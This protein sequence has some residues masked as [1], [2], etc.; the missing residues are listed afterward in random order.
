MCHCVIKSIFQQFFYSLNSECWKLKKMNFT[1]IHAM[2]IEVFGKFHPQNGEQCPRNPKMHILAWVRIVWA[3]K[4]EN[5]STGLTCSSESSN[6]QNQTL[7]TQDWL[8]R[9][10]RDVT[11]EIHNVSRAGFKGRQ[12]GQ[13][14]RASTTNG[15]PQ[16]TVKKLLPKKT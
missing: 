12:T 6:W 13:L 15:P 3:I 9:A 11:P 4:S 7:L 14:P 16:K 10:A 1:P 8:Y 5:P 2:K